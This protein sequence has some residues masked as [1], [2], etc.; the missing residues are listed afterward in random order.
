MVEWKEYK[1]RDVIDKFI[2]YRGKT[3]PKTDRGIPLITAR[4]VKGGRLLE[5]TE[6]ISEDNYIQ[7]MTRGYPEIND[8]ILTTEAPLGEV[9]L[10]RNNRVALAQRIITLRGKK[11]LCDNAFL[12]YYLQSN[13]GQATLQTR[14]Q[15]ST[16]EGIKSAELKE[17]DVTLPSF[18]EQ[19]A[20]AS[21]LSSLDD[22]IDLLQRQNKTLEALAETLFRQ[23]FVE[24]TKEGLEALTL[25]DLI[26]FDP[27]E[28][29]SSKVE[30]TFLDMKCLSNSSMA[31][32]EGIKRT[33]N[34]GSSFRNG[35]TLLAKITPCLE[36]GKTGFVMNL[37]EEDELARGSTEFVVM[38]PKEGISP[39]FVY[40][41]AR[42]SD[43]RNTAI[44][45]MT[46]TSGRQRV[47]SAVLKDYEIKYSEEVMER[48]HSVCHPHFLKIRQNQI[49]ICTLTRLRDTLLPKLMSGEVRMKDAGRMA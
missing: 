11:A 7:W 6:F 46:G 31:I 17:V 36:N 37:I 26:S 42:Y 34:S 33:V 3:P 5:P 18:P 2:D 19:K 13:I 39:Y 21:I 41:L 38:R 25:G 14:A 40:C 16:V 15:G 9:A 43:F 1:L 44:L 8:V 10:L 27:R 30:Y 12:K 23:W 47:Q 24:E 22:K 29:V 48:F 32:S 45:S 28:K 35:D 20:I 49:Q 4:V